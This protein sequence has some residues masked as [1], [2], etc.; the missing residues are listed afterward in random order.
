MCATS[1]LLFSHSV[2]L[3]EIQKHGPEEWPGEYNSQILPESNWSLGLSSPEV[4]PT[5][6][7]AKM[8]YLPLSSIVVTAISQRILW[9]N[10]YFSAQ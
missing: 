6:D 10:K 3:V 2:V 5:E 9:R 4:L 1:S 8:N 7:I